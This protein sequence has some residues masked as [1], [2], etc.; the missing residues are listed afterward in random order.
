VYRKAVQEKAN[1]YMKT[2][3]KSEGVFALENFPRISPSSNYPQTIYQKG[4]VV[5]AMMRA[6]AGDEG[7]TSA[8]KR[9]QSVRKYGTATT[10]DMKE[11][12]R[13]ALGSKTDAFFDE[14]VTGIGWPQ[15]HVDTDITGSDHVVTITQE[16]QKLHPTWPIFTT[17]P[18]NVV[19]TRNGFAGI[20]TIDIIMYPDSAGHVTFT[21][22]QLLSV[23]AGKKCRSLVEV[24]SVTS[25]FFERGSVAPDTLYSL[26]PNPA[27]DSVQL[28]RTHTT[29]PITLRILN[30][31]GKTVLTSACPEGTRTCLLNVSHLASGSYRVVIDGSETVS[32]PLVITRGE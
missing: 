2:I 5:V 10:L 22:T 6:I 27:N 4:A 24:L 13:P 9:Y 26:A 25:S 29:Q 8:M 20:D 30:A 16:Q 7:F 11:A 15:L 14:W 17:L 3:S 28:L 21:C 1:S 31:V 12:L 18:L 23:N 32:L 19:Y